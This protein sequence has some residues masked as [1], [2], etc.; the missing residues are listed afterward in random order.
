MDNE[1]NLNLEKIAKD[2]N[3]FATADSDVV[4]QNI[5]NLKEIYIPDDLIKIY[6]YMLTVAKNPDVIIHLIRCID[7]YRNPASLEFLVD[8]LLFKNGINLSEEEK[9]KYIHA[10]ILCTKAIANLKNTDAVSSL[11]YCMNNK[12][13]HYRVRLACADALGRIGDKFAVAP[14]I[15]VVKDDDEKSVYLRESAVSALGL[16]GDYRAIDPLVSIL[17]AK[18]GFMDK[19]S[20]LK[21]RVIEALNKIGFND[22]ERV[23]KA[24]KNSLMDESAQVRIDAIEGLM[25]SE[26]P[27]AYEIIKNVM[28]EDKDEEVK[29]N[30]LIA[31]YNL[32]DRQILDEVINSSQYSD[33]L[34]MAAVEILDEY[35]SEN[36]NEEQ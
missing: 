25:N 16:L 9:E 31:L 28:V 27:Q 15:D 2:C 10:R 7:K 21:E 19:F 1:I 20:F 29:K 11:L 22:N 34:K 36:E 35:E 32:S 33:A 26:N 6:N 13:E 30:A 5:E 24:L 4:I 3:L 12:N 18:Q 23:F 14:L 17:E 8:I